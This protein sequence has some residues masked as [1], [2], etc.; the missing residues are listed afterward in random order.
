[1]YNAQ[2]NDIAQTLMRGKASKWLDHLEQLG[3]ALI[4]FINFCIKFLEEWSILNDEN[5]ARDKLDMV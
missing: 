4:T 1:M 5:T 2:K 3:T